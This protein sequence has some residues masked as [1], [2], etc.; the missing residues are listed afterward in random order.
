MGWKLNKLQIDWVMSKIFSMSPK[1]LNLW[2][3]KHALAEIYPKCSSTTVA[4][5]KKWP[6]WQ[7]KR[8]PWLS[9]KVG[10]SSWWSVNS[11]QK[12]RC[13]SCRCQWAWKRDNFRRSEDGVLY[14]NLLSV[15]WKCSAR[16]PRRSCQRR[17]MCRLCPAPSRSAE[18]STG[19][20]M[21]SWSSSRLAVSLRITMPFRQAKNLNIPFWLIVL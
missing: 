12:T 7:M 11:S 18:M 1:S 19:N 17:A 21:T 9:W 8:S 4:E 6:P 15:R 5:V 3:E 10:L 13:V 16:K 14:Y 2:G 20:F